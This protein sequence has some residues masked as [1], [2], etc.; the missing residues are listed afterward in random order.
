MKKNALFIA[1]MATALFVIATSCEKDD[2]A[3]DC[4]TCEERRFIRL[5]GEGANPDGSSVYTELISVDVT[6]CY[7][8]LRDTAYEFSGFE[9]GI[10]TNISVNRICYE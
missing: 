1:L 8:N 3:Q 7:G 9:D 6:D 5:T 2:P 10:T 4:V